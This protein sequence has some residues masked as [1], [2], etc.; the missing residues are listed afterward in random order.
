MKRTTQIA[1]CA[2]LALALLAPAARAQ[3]DYAG[4]W[5]GNATLYAVSD[6]N[7]TVSDLSFD[8][9]LDGL[10]IEET[11]IPLGSTWRYFD[12][13]WNLG[14]NWRSSGYNDAAWAQGAAEFGY[15]DGDEATTNSYGN[16]TNKS[17]TTYFRKTFAVADPTRYSTVLI[18]L[19]RD[20]AA[21]VYLNGTQVL[22]SNLASIYDYQTLALSTV[23]G[24]DEAELVEI[25]VP[26]NLL[27]TN[28]VVAVEVHIASRTA[29]DDMSFDLELRATAV[30]SPRTTLIPING[31][32][33]YVVPQMEIG[34]AWREPGFDDSLW[35]GGVGQF[36]YGD[37]DEDTL[38]GYGEATNKNK[39]TYFRREFLVG[40]PAAFSH[41]DLYVMRD[42][43]AAVYINGLEVL[44][45]NL[46]EGSDVN[47]DTAPL[48][49]VSSTN[50]Y[51]YQYAR[52]AVTNL[53]AGTN[54]IAV[55]IHQ[56]ANELG[57]MSIGSPT[58]TPAGL[59]LRLI[60]HA[61]SNG[62]VSLLKDVIQMWKEGT[63]APAPDG[64]NIVV[65]VPGHFVLI[66]DDSLLGDYTGVG[67]KD[68]TPV[69]RRMSAIGFDFEGTSL[70]MGGAIGPS[71]VLVATNT[72]APDFRTNPF[73][74]RYHPDHDNLDARYAEYLQ[75]APE[76]T[77]YIGL[78]FSTRYPPDPLAAEATPPPGWGQSV[79][80]GTY[81]EVLT[82]LHKNAIHVMGYFEL[83]RVSKTGSLNDE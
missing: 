51:Q 18:R 76:V 30:D 8:L 58:F 79:L 41:L 3:A 69:G 53:V 2:V 81:Y 59:D 10:L 39:T 47:Y 46:P 22:R 70:G 72:I 5:V 71:G 15:G 17:V 67:F 48:F 54:V 16:A 44:R 77:R 20:D 31:A 65:G 74:H 14:V 60:V 49:P 19:R 61:A 6:A 29:D 34:T 24:A 37:G 80:G 56:H 35:L 33:K 26:G 52:V 75:E 9:T 63:Y 36:G 45:S 83:Q 50:E 23:D 55:S 11:M 62:T 4:L 64:T 13:G 68:G 43:G 27:Q 78:Y 38:I 7:P 28:N 25:T 57:E 42:D 21:V 12:A 73:L 1:A 66:T 40:D 32:W 82:G